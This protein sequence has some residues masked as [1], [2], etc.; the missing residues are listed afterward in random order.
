MRVIRVVLVSYFISPRRYLRHLQQAPAGLHRGGAGPVHDRQRQHPRQ[1][2]QGPT[3]EA[4]HRLKLGAHRSSRQV[5][6][7]KSGET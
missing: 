7:T 6:E 1:G 5:E 2:G 4:R 3:E